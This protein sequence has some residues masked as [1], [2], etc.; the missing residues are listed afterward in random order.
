MII[1]YLRDLIND[2]RA[3]ENNSK[4]WKIQI[5]MS[6]NFISSNDTGEIRTISVWSDNEEI[7]SGNETNSII[8]RLLK[9]FLTN[10]QNEEKILRNGSN[11]VFEKVNLLSY[12]IHKTSLKRGK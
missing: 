2:H 9:S 10:Y 1:P 3:I 8:R 4:E 6:V 12:H 7:R 5:N 11:F